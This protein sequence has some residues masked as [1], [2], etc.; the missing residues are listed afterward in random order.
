MRDCRS[1]RLR[2]G[3]ALA[4]MAPLWGGCVI[5]AGE[6]DEPL[7]EAAD[8]LDQTPGEAAVGDAGVGDREE[9]GDVDGLSDGGAAPVSLHGQARFFSLGGA[10]RV[11]TTALLRAEEKQEPEPLPWHQE[12]ESSGVRGTPQGNDK[13]H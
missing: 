6:L 1:R 11:G 13:A 3:L 2:G 8:E 12:G 9:G 7:G 10:A 5:A 4:L